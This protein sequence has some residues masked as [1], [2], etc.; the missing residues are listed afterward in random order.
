MISS[1]KHRESNDEDPE[2]MRIKTYAV[3]DD[4]RRQG[5]LDDADIEALAKLYEEFIEMK[6]RSAT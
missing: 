4:M 5:L 1:K 3:F 6:K 2:I